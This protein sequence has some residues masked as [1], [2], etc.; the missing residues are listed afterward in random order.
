MTRP[1]DPAP[2][3]T[4]LLVHGKRVVCSWYARMLAGRAYAVET[5][6]S[7]KDAVARIALG[8]VHA[9]VADFALSDLRGIDLLRAVR[10]HDPDLPVVFTAEPVDV[11]AAAEAVEYGALKSLIEPLS[12]DKLQSAVDRAVQLYRLAR[13][14]RLALLLSGGPAGASDRA[15][16]EAAFERALKGLWL[17]FQPIVR[18]SNRSVFGFEALLRTDEP[19]MPSP[20]HVLNAA[21]RLEQ[22]PRLGRTVRDRTADAVRQAEEF[23]LFVNIHPRDLSD[24]HLLDADSPLTAIAR[25]VVLEITERTPLGDNDEV[26]DAV[27]RLRQLGFRIAVDD[28][29]AGY[30][31]LSNFALLEPD[32]AKLDMTLVNGIEKSSIK[33]KLVASMTALCKDMQMLIIAEGVETTAERDVLLDLGCDLLQGYLYARPARVFPEVMW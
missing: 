13:M 28:L 25:R 29:G 17:A 12:P 19:S 23:T 14:K 32:A 24:P 15:G 2:V 21:E 20:V 27:R 26:I 9:L 8:G 33:R 11:A 16:L 22:L 30:A 1:S 10:E 4:V 7:G 5:I 3:G 18:P 31:G 6:H